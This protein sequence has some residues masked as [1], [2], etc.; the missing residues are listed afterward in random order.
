MLQVL[1][2]IMHHKASAL[3][4]DQ[5]ACTL[6]SLIFEWNYSWFVEKDYN[7]NEGWRNFGAK[8]RWWY[9]GDYLYLD[10]MDLSSS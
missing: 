2:G 9:V 7:T 5:G 3:L 10:S 4:S 8:R 6:W 1:A